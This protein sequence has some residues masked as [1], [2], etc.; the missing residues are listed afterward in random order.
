M[1]GIVKCVSVVKGLGPIFA[2]KGLKSRLVGDDYG[3]QC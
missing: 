2:P 1:K 3:E